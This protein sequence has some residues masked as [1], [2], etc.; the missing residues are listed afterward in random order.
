MSTVFRVGVD[1]PLGSRPEIAGDAQDA[2]DIAHEGTIGL[3]PCVDGILGATDDGLDKVGKKRLIAKDRLV[4]QERFARARAL[5]A[6]SET[7]LGVVDAEFRRDAGLSAPPAAGFEATRHAEI[8]VAFRAMSA[9]EKNAVIHNGDAE[10]LL[11]LAHS[12]N[13]LNLITDQEKSVVEGRILEATDSKRYAQLQVRRA[14]HS[15]AS[16]AVSTAEAWADAKS[17][18]PAASLRERLGA[19]HRGVPAASLRE[20]LDAKNKR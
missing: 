5:L 9:S 1:A 3:V 7:S 17:G 2:F 18:V 11:A 6:R 14:A 4:R 16:Y 12:P 19:L 8:R 15:A 20:R 13:V 10:T